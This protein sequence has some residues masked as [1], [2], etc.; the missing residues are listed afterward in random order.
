M[1]WISIESEWPPNEQ[2]VLMINEYG[3]MRTG[4]FQDCGN[5]TRVKFGSE[6]RAFSFWIIKITHWAELPEPPKD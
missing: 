3:S 5:Y 4:Y 6:S 1:E 2:D